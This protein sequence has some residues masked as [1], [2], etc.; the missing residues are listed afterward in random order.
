MTDLATGLSEA[1][2]EVLTSVLGAFWPGFFHYAG[3]EMRVKI[4]QLFAAA[5]AQGPRQ[6][7]E[8]SAGSSVETRLRSALVSL[9]SAVDAYWNAGPSGGLRDVRAKAVCS[10]QQRALAALATKAASPVPTLPGVGGEG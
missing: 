9:N 6:D 8:K 7:G 1:D 4:A 10:A 2:E 5:R 3:P